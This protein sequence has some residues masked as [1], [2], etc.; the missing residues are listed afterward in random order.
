VASE[1]AVVPDEDGLADGDVQ[2][3]IGEEGG[4][5]GEAVA[6]GLADQFLK[7][8]SDRICL[9]HAIF[10]ELRGE[11]GGQLD[12]LEDLAEFGRSRAD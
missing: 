5:E 11:P 12:L 10:A 3:V 7:G 2:P 1:N 9:V 8:F 4:D 6:N